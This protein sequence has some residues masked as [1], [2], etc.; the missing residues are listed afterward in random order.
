MGLEGGRLARA[1]G[2]GLL[3]IVLWSATFAVARS[4]SEQVGPLTAATAVYLVGGGLCL[5]RLGWRGS[6]TRRVQALSREYLVGCGLLFALYTVTIYLAV[7]LASDRGQLLEIALVNYLWPAGTILLS[8]P[9]LHRR[10]GAWLLPGTA[11]AL[12]GVFLVMTQGARV[13]WGSFVGHLQANPWGYALALIAAAA[14]S[15]YSNL[16]R[17]WVTPGGGGAVELFVPATGLLL[18]L[19]RWLRPESGTWTARAVIEAGVLGGI[20]TLAYVLWDVAMREG[21]LPFVLACSYFTPLLS[22]LVSSA[23]LGVLP[24]ATLWLGCLLI[25]VGSLAS[26]RS[27][28][29]AR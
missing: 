6:F 19:A 4:L 9:L 27:V 1:T 23:Y 7:G 26:W 24:P 14:W 13:S 18:L 29:D 11:V 17:R 28:F 16:A 5:V 15:L 3:A 21:D 10:A 25:V 12:A 22:T 8:L 2:A 20:T